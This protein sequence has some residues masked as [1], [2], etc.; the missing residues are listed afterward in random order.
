MTA[1]EMQELRT[2]CAPTAGDGRYESYK[3]SIRYDNPETREPHGF[4]I[5]P[6]VKEVKDMMARGIGRPGSALVTGTP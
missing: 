3:V 6:T 4:P 5:D 1:D 2:R